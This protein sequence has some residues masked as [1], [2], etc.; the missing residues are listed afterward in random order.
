MAANVGS[1]ARPFLIDV[2]EEDGDVLQHPFSSRTRQVTD[3]WRRVRQGP[4]I[5]DL[6]TDKEDA[7]LDDQQLGVIDLTQD[8]GPKRSAPCR[9]AN[10]AVYASSHGT[11]KTVTTYCVNELKLRVGDCIELK[12]ALGLGDWKIQ[13]VELTSIQVSS[14]GEVVF[15][16]LPYSRTRDLDARLAPKRNEVCQILELDTDVDNNHFCQPGIQIYTRRMHYILHFNSPA[17]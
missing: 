6:P 11:H 7:S 16:G 2:D 8:E 15:C 3:I 9:P 5:R 1:Q 17:T 13:F 14:T 12:E 10:Q 4:V